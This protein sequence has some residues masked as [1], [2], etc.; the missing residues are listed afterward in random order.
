MTKKKFDIAFANK[1]H[2]IVEN[3]LNMAEDYGLKD[4]TNIGEKMAEEEMIQDYIEKIVKYA[5]I[6]IKAMPLKEL[7]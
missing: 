1:A 2:L 6:K 5:K 3:Y 7:V 4:F